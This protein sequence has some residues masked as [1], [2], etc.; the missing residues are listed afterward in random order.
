MCFS[1]NR[2]C[3]RSKLLH[4]K[5]VIDI[6]LFYIL[7]QELFRRLIRVCLLRQFILIQV[8]SVKAYRP[9][10]DIE[11]LNHHAS[12]SCWGLCSIEAQNGLAL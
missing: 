3:I 9:H 7:F 2:C 11:S 6:S 12:N 5:L 10:C 8:K 4:A 1:T